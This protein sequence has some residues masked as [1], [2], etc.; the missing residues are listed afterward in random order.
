MLLWFP[1]SGASEDSHLRSLRRTQT[2]P[3]PGLEKSLN[4][5]GFSR[6]LWG[7]V[8]WFSST[9]K[10]EEPK[11]KRGVSDLPRRLR[12]QFEGAIYRVMASASPSPTGRRTSAD[13]GTDRAGNRKPSP[14]PR[15]LQSAVDSRC[16]VVAL[17]LWAERLAERRAYFL[18]RAEIEADRADD[19]VKGRVCLREEYDKE[20][21]YEK[22]RDHH[23]R[24]ARK[25]QLAADRPWLPI[26][27]D[28]EQVIRGV[29]AEP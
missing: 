15:P 22:L 16:G 1:Q 26:Q 3:G 2:L 10:S 19:F 7:F 28:P 18:T 20:G 5:R 9:R 24:L 27:P 8:H 25:Y 29:R 17:S 21:M 13:H 11:S 14:T 23:L 6:P 4:L 12:I